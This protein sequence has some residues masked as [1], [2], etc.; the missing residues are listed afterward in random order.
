MKKYPGYYS[1]LT[2][3]LS[4]SGIKIYSTN[5]TREYRRQL[6]DVLNYKNYEKQIVLR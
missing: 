2:A 1:K 4:E 6:E 3:Q 5:S